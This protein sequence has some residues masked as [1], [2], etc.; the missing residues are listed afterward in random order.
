MWL[1][2]ATWNRADGGTSF[3]YRLQ[4]LTG[5]SGNTIRVAM[6]TGIYTIL[7]QVAKCRRNGGPEDDLDLTPSGLSGLVCSSLIIWYRT[8]QYVA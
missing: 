2:I 4:G 6:E 1:V 8:L 3:I 7:R 5:S